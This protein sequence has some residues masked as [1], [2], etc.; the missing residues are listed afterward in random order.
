MQSAVSST[1][2]SVDDVRA[3]AACIAANALNMP[4]RRHKMRLGSRQ[5]PLPLSISQL[6]IRHAVLLAV[7]WLAAGRIPP[8]LRLAKVDTIRTTVRHF[9][10][11]HANLL[12]TFISKI[13]RMLTDAG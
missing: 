6:L 8:E 3:T 11:S 12:R 10:V 13:C 2:R 1:K 7:V 4:H 5:H 9:L